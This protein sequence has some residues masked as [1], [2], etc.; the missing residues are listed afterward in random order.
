MAQA[1]L[2]PVA[3][4][5]C[6]TRAP[7][8]SCSAKSDWVPSTYRRAAKAVEDVTL[9]ARNIMCDAKSLHRVIETS[10]SFYYIHLPPRK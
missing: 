6:Q 7:S 5:S 2:T 9:V 4:A 8:Y 10:D 3:G 1:P